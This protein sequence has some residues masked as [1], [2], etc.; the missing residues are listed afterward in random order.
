MVY[1]A[2]RP[3]LDGLL[4]KM[5]FT[6]GSPVLQGDELRADHDNVFGPLSGFTRRVRR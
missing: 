2:A 6:T 4:S 1:S 5:A 3:V